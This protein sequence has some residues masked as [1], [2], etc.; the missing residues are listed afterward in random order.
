MYIAPEYA[1]MLNERSD[2]YGFGVFIMEIIS[3]R[4]PVDYARHL[5]EVRLKCFHIVY[6]TT[7]DPNTKRTVS[8]FETPQEV[9][10]DK[11]II[12]TYDVTLRVLT[13]VL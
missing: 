11:V 4:N 3:G 8:S 5:S 9:V 6:S 1:R 2:V 12:F 13:S 10:E 7:W